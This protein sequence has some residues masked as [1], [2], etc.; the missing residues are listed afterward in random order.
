MKSHGH[1]GPSRH[2]HQ[3]IRR[4]SSAC[5]DAG[6][7][8]PVPRPRVPAAVRNRHHAQHRT[9]LNSLC[10]INKWNSNSIIL[11]RFTRVFYSSFV[12][13]DL[14][15]PQKDPVEKIEGASDVEPV[16]KP[17]ERKE[18]DMEVSSEEI[19]PRTQMRAA[20]RLSERPPVISTS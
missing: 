15:T 1:H 2:Q 4:Q 5:A 18:P 17:D 11:A 3:S 8:R 10:I 6:C 20:N 12:I 9:I 14:T 19:S 7:R 16:A 13:R